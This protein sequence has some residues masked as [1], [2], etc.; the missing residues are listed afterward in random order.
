MIK[1]H[2]LLL[3]FNAIILL[4]C[5]FWGC[6]YFAMANRLVGNDVVYVTQDP[7]RRAF[8]ISLDS[9]KDI[10]MEFPDYNVAF[11]YLGSG[12]VT[13]GIRN[14]NASISFVNNTYFLLNNH[15]FVYGGGWSESFN[16]RN[17]IV[18]SENTA[19]ELFG[20]VNALSAHVEIGGAFFEVSGIIAQESLDEPGFVWVPYNHHGSN[21]SN[22]TGLYIQGRGYDTMERRIFAERFIVAA[23]LNLA[24]LQ[25]IDLDQY[26]ANILVKFNFLAITIAV[27]AVLFFSTKLFH[28]PWSKFRMDMIFYALPAI[29][30]ITLCIF[31]WQS[32][33]A[34]LPPIT[35]A[36]S[37]EALFNDLINSNTFEDMGN[38]SRNNQELRELNRRSN[39][40]FALAVFAFAN[41]AVIGAADAYI[42]HKRHIE[43][44]RMLA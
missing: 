42:E 41:I 23:E 6:R 7:S 34:N 43:N 2:K 19:W 26:A 8:R 9:V 12:T 17:I 3:I 40:I 10:M 37:F 18:L 4:I 30:A 29:A 21:I 25:L 11:E 20:T 33:D 5:L 16:E 28:M 39:L 1:S 31:L 24:N 13:N 27:G 44:R 36:F 15:F 38:L 22:L 35:Q 14:K 32:I